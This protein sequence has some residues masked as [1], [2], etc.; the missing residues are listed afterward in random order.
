M[1]ASNAQI[2]RLFILIAQKVVLYGLLVG[3]AVGLAIIIIQ[4]TTHIIPLDAESYYLDFV[5]MELDWPVI[6]I[7]NIATVIISVAVLILPSHIIARV[8]PASVLSYE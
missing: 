7:L 3:N 8:T 6:V 1:G 5:P 4:R 2:R